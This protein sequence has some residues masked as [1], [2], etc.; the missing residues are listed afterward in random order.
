M[1]EDADFEEA[2]DAAEKY[3]D[4]ELDV[5][6]TEGE[7]GQAE[8]DADREATQAELDA[9]R[10]QAESQATVV[11]T[12]LSGAPPEVA[13]EVVKTV[14][15][16]CD[17]IAAKEIPLQ[18]EPFNADQVGAAKT[19]EANASVEV[20]QA[21]DTAMKTMQPKIDALTDALQQSG[22]DMES[23]K[24]ENAQ[25][26][27]DLADMKKSNADMAKQLNDRVSKV[28]TAM[29]A[30]TKLKAKTEAEGGKDAW[31]RLKWIVAFLAFF[32]TITGLCLWSYAQ[33]KAKTGCYIYSGG[34]SSKLNCSGW[35]KQGNNAA[36]CR[37][38]TLA[39]IGSPAPDC[40]KLID[41]E[42]KYPY[43][44][45]NPCTTKADPGGYGVCGG[46]N[47]PQCTNNP[48]KTVDGSVYY[49]Y[50][51]VPWY[52]PMA[53]V[54]NDIVNAAK[55]AGDD[56]W[57]SLMEMIRKFGIFF[58]IGLAVIAGIILA[59]K[60]LSKAEDLGSH[61]STT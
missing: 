19:A 16:G 58:V 6:N 46:G 54:P 59:F 21:V 27:E 56:I 49:S 17:A 18:Q 23:L 22:V 29:E 45:G 25:M 3:T 57:N 14:G 33:S 47:L 24:A 50:N 32:G 48:D 8:D 37:C 28:D 60:L 41:D 31:S 2:V 39:P 12:K 61:S 9:K 43:C 20:K 5:F 51:A 36:Y 44:L 53:N 55:N 30:N 52:S 26:Q 11:I 4:I 38:G 34:S 40:S 10:A 7:L 35:Y 42:C 15:D 1:S 13:A